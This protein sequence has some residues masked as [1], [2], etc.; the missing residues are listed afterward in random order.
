MENGLFDKI[1]TINYDKIQIN[2]TLNQKLN[3]SKKKELDKCFK[4]KIIIDQNLK[5]YEKLLL[6]QKKRN[7]NNTII[8]NTLEKVLTQKILLDHKINYIKELEDINDDNLLKINKKNI[9]NNLKT[10]KNFTIS[11]TNNFCNNS[12]NNISI[13]NNKKDLNP[14]LKEEIKLNSLKEIFDNYSKLHNYKQIDRG[15]FSSINNKINLMNLSEFSKF[16]SE[17]LIKISRQKLVEIF[18][19]NSSNL[20]YLTFNE[21]LIV[22]EKLS[23]AIHENK[24]QI[25]LKKIQKIKKQ[26]K[27]TKLNEEISNLKIEYEKLKNTTFKEIIENF[28]DYLDLYNKTL[29]R[30]KMKGF[31]IPFKKNLKIK[32]LNLKIDNNEIKKIIELKKK[33]KEKLILSQKKIQKNLLYQNI[34]KL[35]KINNYQLQQSKKLPNES[36]YSNLI[37]NNQ[38]FQNENN[39]DKTHST[40]NII[41]NEN[42]INNKIDDN[43]R[44][45]WEKLDELNINDLKLDENDKQILD[46]SYNSDDEDLLLHLNYTQNK[47]QDKKLIKN[48]S[49]YNI[50]YKNMKLPIINQN[51]IV[52]NNFPNQNYLNKRIFSRNNSELNFINKK[53]N[54][55]NNSIKNFVK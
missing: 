53:I 13:N 28:Y 4:Q 5:L 42:E 3:S 37:L 16:S 39:L 34:L 48:Y 30:K 43:S 24:K 15:L 18:R 27:T 8:Q 50:K 38:N 49:T 6:E 52:K 54:M 32:K 51:K 26:L 2:N 46:D 35:Y 25:I 9:T 7:E 45:S 19:K 12:L 41:K 36:I 11:K 22:I 47:S 14:L 33:E 1:K 44:I 23:L 10:N 17:F 55:Y 21:F 20:N 40:I 29:Y 31:I